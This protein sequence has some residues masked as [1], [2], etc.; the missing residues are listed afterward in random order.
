MKELFVSYEL[1]LKLKEK[2]FDE[3]C[4][5]Y[6]FLSLEKGTNKEVVSLLP[7]VIVWKAGTMWKGMDN[8]KCDS[9]ILCTAPLYQQVIDW[10]REKHKIGVDNSPVLS[11]DLETYKYNYMI[12][13]LN[14]V[15]F[16]QKRSTIQYT[17]YEALD[18]AIEEALK[19]I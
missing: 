14:K 3:E 8:S 10:F 13:S 6:W 1:A 15:D 16:D 18:K 17:Y 9:E 7:I 4:I 5:A 12:Y 19:L 11:T 2:G